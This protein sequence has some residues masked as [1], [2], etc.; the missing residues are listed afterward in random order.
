MQ[1]ALATTEKNIETQNTKKGTQPQKS[2][3]RK[4]YFYE[5]QEEAFKKYIKSDN[6]NEK[7]EIFNSTLY[8]AFS[9]MI[10]SI[11]RKYNLFIPD[12][13][14]DSTFSDTMSFLLTKVE[15]FNISKGYKVYSY[16]GT[17]CKNYLI[18]KK[19]QHNKDICRTSTYENNA[20]GNEI[21][22]IDTNS[23]ETLMLANDMINGMSKE[24][25]DILSGKNDSKLSQ[26]QTMVGYALLEI[27]ENWEI[28]FEHMGSAKF[29]RSSVMFILKEIT[30]MTT[31]EVKKAIKIYKNI[32]KKTKEKLI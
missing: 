10:E 20:F 2:K 12:E 27:I 32:Y 11:I 21:D 8:P 13:D 3:K 25:R 16:C 29:N 1:Q 22:K 9:K 6:Q 18:R 14:F 31:K 24:I 28:L 7:N 30:G 26:P 15:K 17:I 4:G 5:E 23:H 19:V